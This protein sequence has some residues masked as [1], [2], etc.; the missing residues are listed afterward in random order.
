MDL[1]DISSAVVWVDFIT[2]GIHRFF[3]LGRSLDVWYSK[4]GIV[5][6]LSD[7]LVIIL[8]I[9][10]AQFLVPRAS[11]PVLAITSIVVQ[12]IHDYLFYVFIILGV[13]K[14]QNEMIDLFKSYAS[15][16]SWKI[17][18]ADSL[19]IGSTVFIADYLNTLKN[20]VVSFVGLLGLY[21]LTYIIFTR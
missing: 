13:P 8:G 3:N 5:A 18:V 1:L 11:T 9:M 16:S 19:M 20:N 10:I 14:G 2:I 15:E 17:L 7:C 4:F 21:G 6:V 12:L